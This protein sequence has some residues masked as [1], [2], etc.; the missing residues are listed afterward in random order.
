MRVLIVPPLAVHYEVLEPDC[1]VR[2]VQ[3]WRV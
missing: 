1:L 2:V 3:V